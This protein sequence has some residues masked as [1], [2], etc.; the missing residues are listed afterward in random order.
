MY[1]AIEQANS[2]Q[3]HLDVT[4]ISTTACCHGFFVLASVV[5]F[6]KG[7]RYVCLFELIISKDDMLLL[8]GRSTW[9]TAFARPSHTT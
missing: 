8:S 4:D 9:T 1:Q 7:E 2:S 5:D 6:Q 3:A